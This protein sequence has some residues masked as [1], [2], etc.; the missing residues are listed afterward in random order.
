M[1][2]DAFRVGFQDLRH[3]Q[4]SEIFN[5]KQFR[6]RDSNLTFNVSL[7]VLIGI[8]Y[9]NPQF[10]DAKLDAGGVIG[11]SRGYTNEDR[12]HGIYAFVK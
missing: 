6:K 11:H 9:E 12:D 8:F 3:G 4:Q 7:T 2:L 10:L 5:Y 1:G